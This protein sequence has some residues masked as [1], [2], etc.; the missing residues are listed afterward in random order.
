LPVEKVFSDRTAPPAAQPSLHRTSTST[1]MNGASVNGS[2]WGARI[3]FDL[4]E[5]GF[6]VRHVLLHERHERLGL[7]RADINPL[8]VSQLHLRLRALLHRPENQEEIPDIHPDLH[9]VGVG[10]AIIGGLYELHIRLVRCNHV[11]QC[12]AW[13]EYRAKVAGDLFKHTW[14]KYIRSELTLL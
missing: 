3:K 13:A 10:L 2:T 8:K 4:A 6:V 9:A 14:V 7:L 12:N 1:S 5:R 11:S